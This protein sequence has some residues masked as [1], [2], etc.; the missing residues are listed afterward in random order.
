MILDVLQWAWAPLFAVVGWAWKAIGG[1]D[2][3]MAVVETNT[4]ALEKMCDDTS[5]RIETIR[6]E[7]R[8]DRS[9][10]HKDIK[11]LLARK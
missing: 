10:I 7:S 9:E 4:A 3:R 6:K 2:T 8:H 11:T 5:T 1:L